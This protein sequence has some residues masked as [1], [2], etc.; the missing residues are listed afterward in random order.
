MQLFETMVL[1]VHV[2]VALAIVGLVLIQQGK[3]ADMG[4]GFG[5]GASSTVFGSSGSGNFLTRLTTGLAIAFFLTS[6]GLAFF[7]KEHSLQARNAGIPEVTQQAP[8]K[9]APAS[10]VPAAAEQDAGQAN[11]SEVPDTPSAAPADKDAPKQ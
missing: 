4:S 10:D 5:A 8:A 3:G 1:V 7:A 11:T 9:A 2:L 6:F